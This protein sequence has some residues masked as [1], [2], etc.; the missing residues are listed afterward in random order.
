MSVR[1][2]IIWE[3]NTSEELA[4]LMLQAQVCGKSKL[5]QSLDIAGRKDSGTT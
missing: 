2:G 3:F 4:A 5:P 1:N